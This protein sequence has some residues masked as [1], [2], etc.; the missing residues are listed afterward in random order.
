M[1]DRDLAGSDLPQR[2]LTA[3]PEDVDLRT[4]LALQLQKTAGSE[5]ALAEYDKILEINPD[6]L[7]ARYCRGML[8]LQDGTAARRKTT[9]PTFWNIRASKNCSGNPSVCA[10]RLLL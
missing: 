8:A 10:P 6:H 7:R 4:A 2:L 1:L 3:D 9:S 5:A